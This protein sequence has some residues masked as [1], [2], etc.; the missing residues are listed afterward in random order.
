MTIEKKQLIYIDEKVKV[1]FIDSKLSFEFDNGKRHVRIPNIYFFP[2]FRLFKRLFR[3]DIRCFSRINDKYYFFL[4]S[5]LYIVRTDFSICVIREFRNM[6]SPLYFCLNANDNCIYFGD[7]SNQRKKKNVNIYKVGY[8]EKINIVASF[9]P[10]T[11]KH[12]HN[13]LFINNKYYVLTGDNDNESGIWEID[14]NLIVPICVGKQEYRSCFLWNSEHKLCYLTD[15][16]FSHNY[17]VSY[18]TDKNIFSY[19]HKI[20]GPS[21]NAIKHGDYVFFST[22]VEPNPNKKNIFNDFIV[23]EYISDSSIHI[24]KYCISKNELQEVYKFKKDCLN[25]RLFGFGN[26]RLFLNKNYLYVVP[27]GNFFLNNKTI[28]LNIGESNE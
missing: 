5:K 27:F 12:I 8:D 11:V 14:Q 13:I 4:K 25:M 17:I 19:L 21:I 23:S 7:Y 3:Y 9:N 28:V 22:T 20:N 15:S 10:G 16:P 1:F 18:D 2:R 6:S 24:Y 26:A